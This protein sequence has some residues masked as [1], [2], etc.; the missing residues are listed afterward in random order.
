MFSAG[1][2]LVLTGGQT[3][4]TFLHMVKPDGW[5]T[6]LTATQFAKTVLKQYVC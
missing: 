5:P 1:R 3:K 2:Q 4:K 6:V